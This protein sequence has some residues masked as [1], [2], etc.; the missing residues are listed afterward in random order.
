[1]SVLF[2]PTSIHHFILKHPVNETVVAVDDRRKGLPMEDLL[3]CEMEAGYIILRFIFR[4]AKR[5]EQ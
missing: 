4:A 5:I 3:E 2:I 1:M